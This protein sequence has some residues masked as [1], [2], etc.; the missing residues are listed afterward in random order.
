MRI[1][2]IDV[3]GSLPIRRFSVDGLSDVVVIAGPNG[4]G[5]TRLL[6]HLVSYLRGGSP[7]SQVRGFIEATAPHELEAWGGRTQLDL[8]SSVDMEQ[9][10]V[11]LQT[12]RRRHKWK[13]SLI[14]FES[15]RSIQN[16]KPYVFTFDQPDPYEEELGWDTTFGYMHD[17]FQDTVH[18]M[19]RMIGAQEQGI[20]KKAKMLRREGRSSMQLEF[21]DPMA[22]FKEVFATLL[23]PKTL[24]D[25]LPSLQRLQYMQD[26]AVYEFAT[27]SSGERE[28]VNIAFDFLL[29][30]PEDCI[31]FFDEP[32]LHLH[33]ELSY[34]LIQTLQ[35]IGLRNQFFLS[36]HSPDIIS[37]SLD[38][39][40]VFVSP[41][42]E[43]SAGESAN[44][45]LLV[46][47]DDQTHQ[48]LRLLGQSIGI[49]A[50]GRRLVLIEGAKSSLDKQTY[51]SVIRNL[52]PSLVLVPT[53]GKHTIESFEKV[54][55]AVLSQTI[56]GVEF[57]MLCDGDSAPVGAR[58]P[59]PGLAD[60]ARLRVL[61]RYH[62]ENYFLDEAVWADAF[63]LL[64]PPTSWLR[65]PARI[66]A[67][68]HELAQDLVS[69]ATAVSITA[70]YRLNVGNVD[71]MPDDCH[72]KSEEAIVALL[73]AR[74]TTE[75][76][77]VV[78]ALS[79]SSIEASAHD[80]FTRLSESL[81]ADT[82]EWKT[83][84]PGKPLLGRF[85]SRAGLDTARAKTAYLNA[86][87]KTGADTFD[88]VVAIFRTFAESEQ[89]P[90]I[91][92]IPEGPGNTE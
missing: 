43:D 27:L 56:W 77:R 86:V 55:E 71:L 41:P 11:L 51:G 42:R 17:R 4:V 19:F 15:D 89:V 2:D 34:R 5:K 61:P 62:V 91:E 46:N 74:A 75:S 31:V 63:S 6:E 25:P 49:V 13:S 18:S 36:T 84:I 47:E 85:A 28:V 40:V 16:L 22:P 39:S 64:E 37:A 32:E 58:S 14:N 82:D 69:Y 57:F 68:F 44:Q 45:A 52:F 60:S 53:G 50:L 76:L 87:Q 9:F 48:A 26:G 29:R 79:A 80:Y 7:T 12:N 72:G 70:E 73:H 88:E 54:R 8:S 59:G 23:G 66:R 24:A 92:S 10:R 67:C 83:L 3:L 65:A 1:R 81:A 21:D 33:P 78:D 30:S 38:R 20:A 90:M 35:T